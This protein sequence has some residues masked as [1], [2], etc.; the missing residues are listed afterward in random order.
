MPRPTTGPFAVYLSELS[1]GS[2]RTM[3]K[4]LAIAAGFFRGEDP[5]RYPW[6]R[7]RVDDGRLH[8]GPHLSGHPASDAPR[9]DWG[10]AHSAG[11]A[12]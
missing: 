11:A 3:R 10:G 9:R 5:A 12:Q 1:Q 4:A 2:R 7:V 8:R 6:H